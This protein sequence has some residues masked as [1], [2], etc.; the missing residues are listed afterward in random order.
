MDI[1]LPRNDKGNRYIDADIAQCLS[2]SIA[3]KF[4]KELLGLRV[5]TGDKID[6]HYTLR[7]HDDGALEPVPYMVRSNE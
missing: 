5:W 1:K 7:V 2:V 4:A 3:Q 6:L